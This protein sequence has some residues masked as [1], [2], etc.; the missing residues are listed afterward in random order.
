MITEKNLS[1]R[2]MLISLNV[3]GFEGRKKLTEEQLSGLPTEIVR[4]VFDIFDK[5]FKKSLGDIDDIS[6]KARDAIKRISIPF[7]IDGIYFLP[8]G[9]IDEAIEYLE[10][11][12]KTR[13]IAVEN[14]LE[15]YDEAIET[16]K[17]KYPAYYDIAKHSYPSKDRLRNRFYFRYQFIKISAPDKNSLITA[18]QYKAEMKKFKETIEEMKRDVLSTIYQTLLESTSRLKKQCT[19]GKP[20]QRTLN[21]LNTFLTQVDEVY[22][23]FIDHDAMK[24]AI[25][26]LKAN[27]LGITAD[28]LRDSSALKEKFAA[29]IST[30]DRNLQALPDI[31]LKRSIDF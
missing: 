25:N 1:D 26:K 2:G 21:S 14:A 29:E 10:D 8:S 11:I 3:G 16:F 15:E 24:E 4:G 28:S 6:V 12:K 7:S 5:D 27:V 13:S 19:E 20:N 31:P 30:I 17:I 18:A 9:K 22:S 23:D